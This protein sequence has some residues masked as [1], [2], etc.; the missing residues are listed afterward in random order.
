MNIIQ[1]ISEESKKEYIETFDLLIDKFTRE[2]PM[3]KSSMNKALQKHEKDDIAYHAANVPILIRLSLLDIV[4]LFNNLLRTKSGAEQNLFARLICVQLYDL[5]EKVPDMFGKKYRIKTSHLLKY[6][7]GLV[8][9][10]NKLMTEFNSHKN[11]FAPVFKYI[12]NNVSAHRDIDGMKQIKLIEGMDFGSIVE[13][14]I[15][16]INWYKLYTEHED[17]L[18]MLAEKYNPGLDRLIRLNKFK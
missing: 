8:K 5:F 12:R 7:G 17:K 4:M 15:K 1:S 14:F 18:I 10:L 6:D 16:I 2:L 13:A 11:K 9:E 3:I